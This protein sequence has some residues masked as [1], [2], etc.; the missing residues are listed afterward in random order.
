[1]SVTQTEHIPLSISISPDA[2]KEHIFDVLH[3]SSLISLRQLRDDEYIAI[4][5]KN[6][7]NNMKDSKL[8]LKVHRN[9]SD[10]LWYISISNP[11]RKGAHAII[12]RDKKILIS[13]SIYV[14]VVSDLRQENLWR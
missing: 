8:I 13:Y 7:I 9:K 2:T 4:S 1:M 12:T 11:L 10:G 14:D 3:S 5:D 6:E